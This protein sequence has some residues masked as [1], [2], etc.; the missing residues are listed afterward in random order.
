MPPN[1]V[2]FLDS[3][4]YIIKDVIAKEA[5]LRFIPEIKFYL[6]DTLDQMDNIQN[7]LDRNKSS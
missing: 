7:I 6:D 1:F 2:K 3:N 4:K 5:R